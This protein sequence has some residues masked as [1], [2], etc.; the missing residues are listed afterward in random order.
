MGRESRVGL[1]RSTDPAVGPSQPGF[2]IRRSVVPTSASRLDESP[3]RGAT[4]RPVLLRAPGAV[5]RVSSV[6][7]TLSGVVDEIRDTSDAAHDP[8]VAHG[9]WEAEVSLGSRENVYTK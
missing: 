2:P 7:D 4:Q 1:P 3:P 5:P 8:A 9:V 6:A